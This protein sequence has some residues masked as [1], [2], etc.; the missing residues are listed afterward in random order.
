[1]IFVNASDS[2][3]KHFANDLATRATTQIFPCENKKL[4]NSVLK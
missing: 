4:E 3:S 2:S 1:M